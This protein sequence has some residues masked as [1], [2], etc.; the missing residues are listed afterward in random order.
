MLKKVEHIEILFKRYVEYKNVEC[1]ADEMNYSY[2]YA[3][4]LLNL[5]L[6]AFEKQHADKL[7]KYELSCLADAS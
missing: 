7:E 5:A 2:K 1:I 3:S 6:K 4:K